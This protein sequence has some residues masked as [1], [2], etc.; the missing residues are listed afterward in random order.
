MQL[1]NRT[2]LQHAVDDVAVENPDGL[3]ADD[4]GTG[5]VVE[6]DAPAVRRND[7]EHAR[8]RSLGADAQ[9][10]RQE[11]RWR[12]GWRV[13]PA[14]DLD[15][16]E[17]GARRAHRDAPDEQWPEI[18]ARRAFLDAHVAALAIDIRQVCAETAGNRAVDALDAQRDLAHSLGQARHGEAQS[19]LGVEHPGQKRQDQQQQRTRR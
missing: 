15:L 8:A 4:T 5:H 9:E 19:G 17:I 18:D 10:P 1:A 6:F 3:V 16:H 13:Q 11:F 7:D 2:R 14:P 12:I